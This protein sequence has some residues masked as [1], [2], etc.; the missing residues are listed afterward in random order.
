[1]QL[2]FLLQEK[3]ALQGTCWEPPWASQV[4]AQD[5]APVFGVAD[6]VAVLTSRAVTAISVALAVITVWARR[7]RLSFIPS[8]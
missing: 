1:M 5:M 8:P 3:G 7:L 2:G 4:R 6:M